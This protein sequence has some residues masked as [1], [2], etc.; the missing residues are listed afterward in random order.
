MVACEYCLKDLPKGQKRTRYFF[1]VIEKDDKIHPDGIEA[2][3]DQHHHQ[4]KVCKG[5]E[6]TIF[7]ERKS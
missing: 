4:I 5:C 7:T 2:H 3:V 6:K 1:I